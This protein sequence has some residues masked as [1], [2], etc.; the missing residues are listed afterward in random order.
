MKVAFEGM[1]G[2]GK[3]STAEEVAKRTGFIH[4]TQRMVNIMGIDDKTFS[5][6][7]KTVR[8]STNERLGFIFYTLRCLSD[9]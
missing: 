5:K 2:V 9:A 6:L 1:D 8:N 7:V 4:E 3:S